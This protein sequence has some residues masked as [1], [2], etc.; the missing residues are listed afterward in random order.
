MELVDILLEVL[1][2]GASDLHLAAGDP[3]IVR[4]NGELE[5]LDIRPLSSGDVQG[6]VYSILSQEQR[7]KLETDWEIDLSY[8]VPDRARFRVNAFF[9]LNGLSAAFRLIPV[10]T[11]KL[12]ELGLP[13]ILHEFAGMARGFVIITGPTG[14][15][16][17][18]TLAAMIDEI[19][20]TRSQHIVTIE[21]PV[22]FLHHHKKCHVNQ[23]EVGSTTGASTEP[24]G[25]CSARTR[26][27][28]SWVRC[29]TPRPWRRR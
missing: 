2:R 29:A 21:D 22:E 10:H 12:D 16:K 26:T 15:G 3:P 7:Q 11:P 8:T 19:N 20:R 1:E 24:S 28:S 18:T 13:S 25:A 23:R 6:L 9:Q 14:S 17:S 27:S 4:V 5:P